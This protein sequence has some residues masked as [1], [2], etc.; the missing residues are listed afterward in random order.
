VTPSKRR[1]LLF[2]L[3]VGNWIALVAIS[4]AIAIQATASVD[5]RILYPFFALNR[6]EST[7]TFIFNEVSPNSTMGLMKHCY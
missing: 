7:Y 1:L 4:V 3:I 2:M 6:N 5:L